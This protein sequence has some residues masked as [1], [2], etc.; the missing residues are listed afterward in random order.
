MQKGLAEAALLAAEATLA[1]APGFVAATVAAQPAPCATC[2]GV[3]VV[4]PMLSVGSVLGADAC[5]ERQKGLLANSFFFGAD[6][7]A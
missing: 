4:A 3:T 5:K 7:S 6:G 2:P 1:T